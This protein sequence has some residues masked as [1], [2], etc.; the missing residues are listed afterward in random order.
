M[1]KA[2]FIGRAAEL[3]LVND[4]ATAGRA[5]LLILYGRRRI[6][7]TRLLTQWIA[8]SRAR[9]L[10][11]VAEPTSSLDQLRSFSQALYNFANPGA[12]APADAPGG[13]GF[14][15]ASWPQ[16]LQQ[17]AALAQREP[18]ALFLDEFTYLLEAEPGLAGILQNAW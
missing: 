13:R 7:K 3:K 11:W 9:A 1:D 17:A 14:T 4:L 2:P 10:Y 6:G 15:Y 18:F 5:A 16:A 12:P 8:A